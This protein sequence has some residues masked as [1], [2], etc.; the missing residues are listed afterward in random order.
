MR[1]PVV[2]V[3]LVRNVVLAFAIVFM[4]ILFV[5]YWW[6]PNLVRESNQ[7]SA[8]STIL[9]F[10]TEVTTLT[11]TIVSVDGSSLRLA[12]SN[13]PPIMEER[14]HAR[15][16]FISE[17]TKIQRAERKDEL[18]YQ[19]EMNAFQRRFALSDS[20]TSTTAL[21]MDPSMQEGNENP[22]VYREYMASSS[23]VVATSADVVTSSLDPISIPDPLIY[24]D[25]D[26]DALEAGMVVTVMA[27]TPTFYSAE[28]HATRIIVNS[29]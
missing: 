24:M 23:T 18:L 29:Q 11:G 17:V 7:S 9:N 15:T 26:S 4:S 19:Q 14:L 28:I 16:V 10:V 1:N 22:L 6:A 5:M 27:E 20:V 2:T 21:A 3:R 13:P 25:I 12:L 8:T